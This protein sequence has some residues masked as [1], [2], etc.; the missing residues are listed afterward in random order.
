MYERIV[1]GVDGFG[2]GRDALAL[3]RTLAPHGHLIL[4]NAYGDRLVG[5]AERTVWASA[6]RDRAADL[7]ADEAETAGVDAELIVDPDAAPA[8]AIHDLATE[9]RA[10]LIVLGSA[11]RSRFGR[12]LLGDIGRRVMRQ[13]PTPVAVAPRSYQAVPIRTVG[14]AFDGGPQSR[15]ALAAAV[16]LASSLDARLRVLIVGFIPGYATPYVYP[17]DWRRYVDGVHEKCD[18][19]LQRT[20]VDLGDT[21]TGEVAYGHPADELVR[22]SAEIDLLVV[23]SRRYG[24]V[25]R[26]VLGSTSDRLVHE[27]RCPVL[28]VPRGTGTGERDLAGDAA[29]G[30]V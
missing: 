23:G 16:G 15:E 8:R 1:I 25:R 19:L 30:A 14:V 29:R 27:A 11:H 13:A 2:G 6:M 24:P 22:A 17:D 9:R 12:V 7:L 18:V 3:A 28:V 20:L 4:V 10:D 26:V 5:V 21:A